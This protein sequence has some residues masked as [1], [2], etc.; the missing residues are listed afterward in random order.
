MNR[1]IEDNLNKKT[2]NYILPF[3]WMKGETEDVIVREIE[4]I[5]EAGIGAVCLESRPHPDFMGEKWWSDFDLILKECK[6]R[7]MKIWILDDSHFPTGLA[8]GLL[9]AKYP[10]RARKYLAVKHFDMAGPVVHGTLDLDMSMQKKFSWMDI[11]KPMEQPLVSEKKAVAVHAHRLISG[12][13]ISEDFIDFTDDI[14]G[15]MLRV[16]LPE[17]KWRILIV[18]TTY[19]EGAHPDYIHMIDPISVSTLIEAVYEPHYEHYKDEF[20]KTIAGFFSDEPG[21]YNVF[22]FE[23]NELIG[24]KMMPLPWTDELGGLLLEML[25]GQYADLL[26]FLWYPCSDPQTAADVRHAYMDAVTQLYQ[27]HFSEQLGKWCSDHGVEYIGHVLEDNNVST[28]LGCGAGH[29]FRAMSGQAMAGMDII[30]GQI[31]PG[32][33]DTNRHEFNTLDGRFF[34]YIETKMGASAAHFQSG[35]QGRLMCEAFGAYGW[36]FGV[37]DMKWLADHLI[38][39]GV[40]TL[41]PHAF[42]MAPYPDGDC[43]PHFY[44]G[45]HNP[46][47]RYFGEL[48]RY[49]NRLMHIFQNGKWLPEVGIVYRAESEWAGDACLEE[50]IAELLHKEGIDYAIVPIDALTDKTRYSSEVK[51]GKLLI[52]DIPLSALIV[53]GAEYIDAKLVKFVSEH[54][55]LPVVIA[56]NSPE[57]VCGV[58]PG[59]MPMEAELE[60]AELADL[61]AW[62]KKNGVSE[63]PFVLSP[64]SGSSEKSVYRYR[65]E[66]GKDIFMI[67]NESLTEDLKGVLTLEVS[68]DTER[69]AAYDALKN[70]MLPLEQ[71]CEGGRITAEISL[72]PYES[73]VIITGDDVPAEYPETAGEPEVL[74]ISAGWDVFAAEASDEPIYKELAHMEELQP[75]SD[76]LP[77]FS[78]FMRYRK[79]IEAGDAAGRRCFLSCEHVYEAARIL[80]NGEEADLRFC[81]PYRF[82]LTGKLR[83]G[84]NVIEIEAVN[85]PLRDVLNYDQAPLGHERGVYE[86]SGVFGKVLLEYF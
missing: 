67:T 48:M 45:G 32:M 18:H 36:S 5:H 78:G 73:A 30:G 14:R 52:N 40:N 12:D 23:M 50:D 11:G 58:L 84:T 22:G 33:P 21:F 13:T 72:C 3:L 25:G 56:G 10:E 20:G 28:R 57:G 68:S 82:D 34:H 41:V 61:S 71:K 65:S 81:P 74:D 63:S 44:A 51:D 31:V 54:P 53:P 66:D 85:T 83:E 17:G 9:A 46:E 55:D 15:G 16:D 24:R 26:P 37:R 1:R 70:R 8:N 76:S 49:S 77:K 86:P 27:K 62:L 75:V 38:S 60:T 69:A 43:P 42:S 19:D 80:V 29:Y 2:G 39:R 79:E 4:K 7:D 35:K 47:F 6:K 64:E 59:D